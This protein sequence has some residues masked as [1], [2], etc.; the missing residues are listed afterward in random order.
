MSTPPIKSSVPRKK[1]RLGAR[2]ADKLARWAGSWTFI[3]LFF[4]FLLVWIAL[5]AIWLLSPQ[6]WDPYPFILLNL[7]LSCLAAIQAPIILMSQNRAAEIDRER[8]RKD[9][10]IN[11]KAEKEIKVLQLDL[12]EIKEHLFEKP[13]DQ[14]TEK[15]ETDIKK[16]QE[17]LETLNK[18]H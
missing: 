2:A 9:Y 1:T 12:L 11:R 16:L 10:Y 6:Q 18:S 4:L 17:E 5:N 3:T 13:L 14:R 15:L 8:A 7:V